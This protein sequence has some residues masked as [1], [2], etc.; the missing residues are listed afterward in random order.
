MVIEIERKF[1]LRTFPPQ[2]A[3]V[4]LGVEALEIEQ[5]YL[6]VAAGVEERIRA[7]SSVSGTEYVHTFL[8]AR[9]AGV[10]EIQERSITRAEYEGLRKSADQARNPVLKRRWKFPFEGHLLELDD[11]RAPR[12]RACL[13]LEVQIADEHEEV[14]L[15]AFLDLER[16][17]TGERDYSNADISQG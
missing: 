14:I 2:A 7:T 5:C 3:L 1:L 16:E 12:S 10:R 17:V 8:T 13:L 4:S 11:I 6:K 9:R 15:P